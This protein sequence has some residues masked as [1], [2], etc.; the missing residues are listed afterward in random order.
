[1]TKLV[2]RYVDTGIIQSGKTYRFTAYL[3]Y[4]YNGKQIRKTTTF[5]PPDGLTSKKADK[6]AKEE[7]INFCNHQISIYT[8]FRESYCNDNSP[9][10]YHLLPML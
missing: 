2:V 3:G 9:F 7:Y 8:K 10:L 5:V 4:D 1:M 6:L